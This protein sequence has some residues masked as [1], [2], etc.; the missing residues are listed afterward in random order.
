MIII[1]IIDYLTE[2]TYETNVIDAIAQKTVQLEYV[3]RDKEF[4][5]RLLLE[6]VLP[7]EEEMRSIPLDQRTFIDFNEEEEDEVLVSV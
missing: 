5:K 2:N 3:L 4:M 7:T 6:G 1:K